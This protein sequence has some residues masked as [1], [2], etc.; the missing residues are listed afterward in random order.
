MILWQFPVFLG[1]QGLYER[2]CG[3][4]GQCVVNFLI[5]SSDVARRR[6]TSYDVAI[7]L[8]MVRIELWRDS[9]PVFGAAAFC[10]TKIEDFRASLA[11]TSLTTSSMYSLKRRSLKW[12][13]LR[14]KI[15]E[16]IDEDQLEETNNESLS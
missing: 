12:T 7:L 14:R 13:S 2:C 15:M 10:T 16:V 3:S 11:L 8:L 6:Q 4:V 1:P 5:T 9:T